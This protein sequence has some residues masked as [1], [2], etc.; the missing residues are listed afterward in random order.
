M[1]GEDLNSCDAIT[2][3]SK[4]KNLELINRIHAFKEAQA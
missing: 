1:K 4:Q 2:Q 3:I